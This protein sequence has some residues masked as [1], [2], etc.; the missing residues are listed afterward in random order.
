[1]AILCTKKGILLHRLNSLIRKEQTNIASQLLGNQ[2]ET[3]SEL[4]LGRLAKGLGHDLVLAQEESLYT[5]IFELLWFVT[6]KV[7]Q[8]PWRRPLRSNSLEGIVTH[9]LNWEE[10]DIR[11]VINA[12]ADLLFDAIWMRFHDPFSVSTSRWMRSAITSSTRVFLSSLDFLSVFVRLTVSGIV[13]LLAQ[14]Q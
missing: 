6:D 10:V 14:S 7:W 9:V 5:T 3:R 11:V 8:L 4:F 2:V 13:S 12:F 1:M